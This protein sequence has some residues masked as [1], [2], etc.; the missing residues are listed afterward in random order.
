MNKHPPIFGP[1]REEGAGRRGGTSDELVIGLSPINLS[2]Q[3]AVTKITAIT[4][5]A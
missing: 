3:I 5:S 2:N 4:Q 1:L